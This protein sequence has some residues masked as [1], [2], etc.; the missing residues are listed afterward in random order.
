MEAYEVIE[1]CKQLEDVNVVNSYGETSVFYNPN[2]RWKRGIYVLT[3]KEKDGPNDKASNLNRDGIYRVNL[4]IRKETFIKL[5]DQLPA[6][7]K[8]GE[9]VSMNFDFTVL[10]QILP[11]PVYAWMGWVSILN[12]IHLKDIMPYIEESYQ[13]AKEKMKKRK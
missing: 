10:N 12:P 2:M 3:I 4:G 5:F 9:V 1:Y 7:P 8:A 11:H 13:Y 6:R